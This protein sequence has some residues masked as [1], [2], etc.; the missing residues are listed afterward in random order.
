MKNPASGKLAPTGGRIG[1]RLLKLL[2]AAVLLAGAGYLLW[3]RVIR[4]RL[5]RP[6]MHDAVLI[7]QTA[8]HKEEFSL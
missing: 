5:P 6:V 3:L 1:M 8:P 2:L 4:P 7:E